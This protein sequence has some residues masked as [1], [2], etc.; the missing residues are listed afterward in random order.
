MSLINKLKHSVIIKNITIILSFILLAIF[1]YMLLI[2][3]HS[4]LGEGD[5]A[6]HFRRIIELRDSIIHYNFFPLFSFNQYHGSA[7]M[8]LYPYMNLYPI[9]L[10]AIIIKSKIFLLYLYY[11]INASL[12]LLIS[13]YSSYS[14]NKSFYISYL[15][16]VIYGL[17]SICFVEGLDDFG[18][19]TS[20][21]CLPLVIFGCIAW[22]RNNKYIELSIGLMLIIFSHVLMAILSLMFIFIWIISNISKINKYR[23]ISLI[24]FVLLTI[25][26][27]SIVWIPVIKFRLGSDIY[28]PAHPSLSYFYGVNS[29]SIIYLVKMGLSPI[30]GNVPNIFAFLGIYITI[31]FYKNIS[32]ILKRLLLISITFIFIGSNLFPWKY[33]PST[34]FKIFGI[35]QSPQRFF[36][37]PQILLSYCFAVIIIKYVAYNNLTKLKKILLMVIFLL[38]SLFNLIKFWKYNQFFYL[39]F[40]VFFIVIVLLI[41]WNKNNYKLSKLI[42]FTCII[43]SCSLVVFNMQQQTIY[44]HVKHGHIITK[45]YFNYHVRHNITVSYLD[46]INKN[47]QFKYLVNF[48]ISPTYDYYPNKSLPKVNYINNNEAKDNNNLIVHVKHVGYNKFLFNSPKKINRLA[49]PLLHYK[50]EHLYMSVN[51]H[52][53][54][55]HVNRNNLITLK[56]VKKGKNVITI[57][58]V[59]YIWLTLLKITL[60]INGLVVIIF[61][62]MKLFLENDID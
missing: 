16:S 56:D 27:T 12:L 30:S 52:L 47:S 38:C 58:Y 3:T 9:A 15:F 2:N 26:I 18:E 25:C 24:K 54:H 10:L 20:Y 28:T 48:K 19:I 39:I 29:T 33:L 50:G 46:S 23:I 6:F 44:Q 11:I 4:I 31:L 8:M 53:V 49:L 34:I 14:T 7:V 42:I 1:S 57:H 43:L 22:I 21:A 35:F 62:W 32:Y 36:I 13:F 55:Y 41:I 61:L 37:I 45:N 51:H 17:S 40:S 5:I 60:F 59:P